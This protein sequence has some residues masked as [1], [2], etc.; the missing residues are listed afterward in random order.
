MKRTSE[1]ALTLLEVAK[2]PRVLLL[3]RVSRS[4][5]R[6]GMREGPRAR[7]VQL[8]FEM[9]LQIHLLSLVLYFQ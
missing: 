9:E 4:A 2:A 6:G 3:R 5:D 7:Q 8:L 1:G